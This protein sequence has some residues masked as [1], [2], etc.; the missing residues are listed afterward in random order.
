MR[1]G[2]GDQSIKDFSAKLIGAS[3]LVA[4]YSLATLWP[5]GNKSTIFATTALGVIFFVLLCVR[6]ST[7]NDPAKLPMIYL[8]LMLS[9]SAAIVIIFH[10]EKFSFYA[11]NALAAA[12]LVLAFDLIRPIHARIPLYIFIAVF[13]WLIFA[14]VDLDESIIAIGQNGVTLHVLILY[15]VYF[16]RALYR[17]EVSG[18]R[19]VKYENYVFAAALFTL[20]V[21]SQ[22]RAATVTALIILCV[23]A[24]ILMGEFAGK[25]KCWVV[26]ATLLI[27]LLNY[28]SPPLMGERPYSAIDRIAL[29]GASDVRYEVWV[30]YFQTLTPESLVMGN[31]D[32]N[33]HNILQGY[34]RE[35]CN[36]HSSYLR[37][38][39]AYGL[40][41]VFVIFLTIFW[42]FRGL[43]QR[44]EWFAM[45][46][47]LALLA[48]VATDE[49]FFISPYLFALFFIS[50]RVTDNVQSGRDKWSAE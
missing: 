32:S 37:A 47:V 34:S 23:A 27:V 44:G 17:L 45:A 29:N 6:G 8:A 12:G 49:A 24:F 9:L 5:L 42:C 11:V 48:R 39:Q 10:K 41:G 21:W 26:L 3:A 33:C 30:D 38:H 31:R 14:G 36:V 43:A 40:L 22:G 50:T 20:A 19:V 1:K 35:N 13:G 7:K 15:V 25:Q 4:F 2:E 28:F 16:F 46:I 18:S